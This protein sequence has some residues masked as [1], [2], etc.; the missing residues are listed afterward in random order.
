MGAEAVA[1]N[2]CGPLPIQARIP[3]RVTALAVW[4]TRP[5]SVGYYL[6]VV[7]GVEGPVG[8]QSAGGEDVGDVGVAAE[9]EQAVIELPGHLTNPPVDLTDPPTG[10]RLDAVDAGVEDQLDVRIHAD[11]EHDGSDVLEVVG[12][13]LHQVGEDV[14]RA[15]ALVELVDPDLDPRRGRPLDAAVVLDGDFC[16]C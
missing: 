3:G 7:A 15:L 8:P 1:C 10:C 16:F 5:G 9:G 14:A 2:A 4:L 6:G 13:V 11:A 12:H